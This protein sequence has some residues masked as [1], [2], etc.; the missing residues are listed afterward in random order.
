LSSERLALALRP[1]VFSPSEIREAST[2]LDGSSRIAGIFIPDGRSGY[3]AIEIASS[4]LALT[5]RVYAGSGVIRLLEHDPGLLTR[6][7]QTIQAFSSNRLILG[8]GT[9]T[10]GPQPGRSVMAMLQRLDELY[11]A[12]QSFPS[13]VEPPEVYVATLKTGIARRAVGKADG[14]L[15]NFCSPQHAASLVEAVKPQ[16]GTPIE[17]AC[18]LK[19]FYSSQSDEAARRLLAQEFLNYDSAP[20]YHEMFL[21]DRTADV[22]A[23]FREKDEWKRGPVQLPRELLR[24]SL[25]NP[26]D[27]ELRRYVQSF[28]QAGVTLPVPYPYFPSEEKSEF[29]LAT[30]KRIV[31]SL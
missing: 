12:F 20:Q 30:V 31:K 7:V 4:I 9:G 17:F 2:V 10:P 13:G 27:D 15:L 19:I 16:M 3:E 6:R 18:Y 22:I 14:L 24:V 26:D 11:K 21:Q 23:S 28:R 8:V 25:A 5:R 29:K 1:G